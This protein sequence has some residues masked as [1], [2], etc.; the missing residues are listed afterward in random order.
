R[1]PLRACPAR[2]RGPLAHRPRRANCARGKQ[3]AEGRDRGC[4]VAGGRWS[5]D[6]CRLFSHGCAPPLV[7]D[8]AGFRKHWASHR[9]AGTRTPEGRHAAAP[10]VVGAQ[11]LT[12]SLRETQTRSYSS[13]LPPAC[14]QRLTASLRETHEKLAGNR[15]ESG[16][17]STPDGVIAGNTLASC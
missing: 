4:K 7:C 10:A 14:A 1:W 5:L 9:R 2:H 6:V 12:A 16:G 8:K 3:N 11:R 13:S 15:R 17:C